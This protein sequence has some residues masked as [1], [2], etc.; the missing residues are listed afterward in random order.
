MDAQV[1]HVEIEGH[2]FMVRWLP[3]QE[4]MVKVAFMRWVANKELPFR[5]EAAFQGAAVVDFL[6]I[7][8]GAK[9]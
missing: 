9:R 4:N 8:Q 6:L 3:G 5:L 2:H 1:L 7:T